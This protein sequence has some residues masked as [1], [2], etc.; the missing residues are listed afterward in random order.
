MHFWGFVLLRWNLPLPPLP[1][2]PP[3]GVPTSKALP[4]VSVLDSKI[5]CHA[6]SLISPCIEVVLTETDESE[7]GFICIII[8]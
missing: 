4:N 7:C 6:S 3:P 2:A 5:A 8:S 1:P